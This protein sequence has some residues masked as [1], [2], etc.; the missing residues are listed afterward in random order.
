M[1]VEPDEIANP[2]GVRVAGKESG[3]R[4]G[5]RVEVGKGA[6]AVGLV[7][8]T[9]VNVSIMETKKGGDEDRGMRG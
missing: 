5:M 2:V 6:V 8:L 1:F 4:D 3:V 9:D 7:A